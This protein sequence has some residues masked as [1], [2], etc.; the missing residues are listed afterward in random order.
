MKRKA[1]DEKMKKIQRDKEVWILLAVA[2]I[3]CWLFVLQYGIFGSRVDWVSQHSVLPDY[4]RQRFYATGNLFPDIAWNL[5]GGQNIYNFSYYGLFSPVILFSYLLPF[6]P[7]DLYIMASSMAAYGASV[8]L[9]YQWIKKKFSGNNTGFW[10]ACMFALAGPLIFHSYNQI[11]F[12]NY[13]P[14]LCLA[15]IGT[16][17]FLQGKKKGLLI[18]GTTGMIL[19]SFYFS[20][21]G[22]LTLGLY[23]TGTYIARTEKFSWK[24]F[25][26][27]A[28]GFIGPLILSLC[29][30]GVLLIPT[31]LVL[32]S[33]ESGGNTTE[34]MGLFSLSPLRFFYSPYGLGLTYLSMGSLMGNFL[35]KESWKKKIIPAGL[36]IILFVP[37]FGY[38]LNGGLY[39][40][41]KVF[42][43]FLPLVCLETGKYVESLR[44]GG[45]LGWPDLLVQVLP[46]IFLIG[47][48]FFQENVQGISQKWL[49]GGIGLAVAVD[50]VLFLLSQ[51]IYGKFPRFPWPLLFSVGILFFSGWTMN[52]QWQ[53]MLPAEE[54]EKI[55]KP[56]KTDLI[57]EPLEKDKGWYRMEELEGGTREFADMNR[58]RDIGQ[59]ISSIYSSAYNQDYAG[60]R[61][62][63]F[64]VNRHFRNYLME[65]A[66]DNPIFLNLMGVRYVT[67]SRPPA[68]YTLLE[69][70]GD[71]CLYGNEKALPL[72]FV[73][74]RVISE[75]EYRKLSFPDNQSVLLQYG[76]IENEDQEKTRKEKTISSMKACGLE[77][78]VTEGQNI[79][80]RKTENGYEIY[81]LKEA[82]I[83]VQLSGRGETDDLL[84]VKFYVK[85][86]NLQK[87]MY[88]R[89]EGQ[90][91]RLSAEKGYEYANK[92]QD[93]SYTVTTGEQKDRVVFTFGKGSYVIE[94]IQAFTGNLEKLREEK[95]S[96]NP[97][98][99]IWFS[100]GGDRLTGAVR[101][102]NQGYLITSIPYDENFKI[103]VDGEN[104]EKE[105][106]NTAF[107][108]AKI[109]EGVHSISISYQAPGKTFGL[110]LTGGGL[111]YLAVLALGRLCRRLP[112]GCWER[113]LVNRKLP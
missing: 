8:V 95:L 38:L 109:P 75:K 68:G 106:V 108:G 86:Q 23:G 1:G 59:N 39:V 17:R 45:R 65:A 6:V 88:I 26:K 36:L 44:K 76:V 74:D 77:L 60:F 79:Q 55:I 78:P 48:S 50:M 93:F 89:L 67:A 40:K 2:L 112:A 4:F 54:Y 10:T 110:L 90:T 27:K 96:E 18:L 101:T 111:V 63:T 7:M 9:F 69:K 53:K 12:V 72:A 29:L 71:T 57:K 42:I 105:K 94:D 84:A 49:I 66:T 83:T 97:L 31:A 5:G 70:E 100:E 22:I 46:G 25:G 92:N 11:M 82:E 20:V 64:Q 19:T 113:N 32:L 35:R 62:K 30:C 87:D 58:I 98:E 3:L 13:M 34:G 52:S 21:G 73:T 61:D 14:F 99:G 102:E 41:D 37:V 51:K 107:L 56:E 80:I 47:Y 85:N 81:A 24:D 43:P 104:V 103:T 91:N 15:L 16:D 28:G 33:R